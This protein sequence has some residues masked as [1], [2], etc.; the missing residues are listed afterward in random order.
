RSRIRISPV[1]AITATRFARRI[2][3][4]SSSLSEKGQSRYN[5]LALLRRLFARR[6]KYLHRQL[7]R[8][9]LLR[10]ERAN[11]HDLARDLLPFTADYREDYRILPGLARRWMLDC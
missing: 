6:R 2:E 1:Q 7:E 4:S 5:L 3:R 9:L 8:P 11:T 10:V